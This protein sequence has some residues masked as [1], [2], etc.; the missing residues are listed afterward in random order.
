ME[1]SQVW[2]RM[3]AFVKNETEE[4]ERGVVPTHQDQFLSQ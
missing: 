2:N 4:T 3:I 1:V